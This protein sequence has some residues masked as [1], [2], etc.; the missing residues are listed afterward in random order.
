MEFHS[1]SKHQGRVRNGSAS[2]FQK[3]RKLLY[4]WSENGISFKM[5]WNLAQVTQF[6]LE[7][8]Y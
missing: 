4:G 2:L 6:I 5:E 1:I 7:N 3:M 8:P